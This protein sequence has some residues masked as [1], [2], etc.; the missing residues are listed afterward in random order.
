[1]AFN[2]RLKHEKT[3]P[4]GTIET[5]D[6]EEYLLGVLGAEMGTLN[7]HIE[8][9]KAQ[10]IAARTYAVYFSNSTREYDVTDTTRH[11]AYDTSK[12]NDDI[13]EA[14]SA[15]SGKVL[16]YKNQVIESVYCQCNG[17][18][19]YSSQEV[20][21]APKAYLTKKQDPWTQRSTWTTKSGHGVG[22][23][24]RGAIQAAKEGTLYREILAFY[25]PETYLSEDYHGRKSGTPGTSTQPIVTDIENK[26]VKI[27]N[28]A[29]ALLGTSYKLGG[30]TPDTG[31]D[32]A[33]FV[34]YVYRESIDIKWTDNPSY[35][36]PAHGMLLNAP[37]PGRLVTGHLMLGDILYYKLPGAEH[38]NHVGIYVGNSQFIHMVENSAVFPQDFQD[39][40]YQR[41]YVEARRM[42][43]D[44]ETSI[45]ETTSES[46]SLN[47]TEINTVIAGIY[48]RTDIYLD[49]AESNISD[50]EA[51]YADALK[52]KNNDS[53]G[54]KNIIQYG[55]LTDLT[56]G[57]EF[58]FIVPEF[59]ESVKANWDSTS[60]LGS[61][62]DV[63]GY[64]STQS[65]SITISIDVAAG[66]HP[67]DVSNPVDKLIA[68]IE[69]LQS[70]V[71]PD[72]SKAI[73]FPPPNVLLYLSTDKKLKGIVEDVS[74]QYKKPYD[75]MNRPMVANI[76]FTVVQSTDYP[77]DYTDIRNSTKYS[78]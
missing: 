18:R 56:N 23:S 46:P 12:I 11:Q 35:T 7:T 78:Y 58:R 70:L 55:Y 17:G 39:S 60:V 9:L 34:Q 40:Y 77:P 31:F 73:V 32:S 29:R 27:V 74:V 38:V 6:I 24:Q 51:R 69:F 13:R 3:E 61:S 54:L 15:T 63:K 25:Y 50:I 71:Y 53:V 4:I 57:G 21:G 30:T 66:V 14:V 76:S 67:Y 52:N 33:S 45:E 37:G 43:A 5:L 75:L 42:V 48:S 2:I 20:W 59:D 62:A 22:M 41:Y 47:A 19:T 26:G 1:M 49:A 10:A 16:V 64:N 68:D 8:A 44:T 28:T 72:Y 36:L 65:K